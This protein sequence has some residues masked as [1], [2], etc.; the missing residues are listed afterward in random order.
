MMLC[1]T[2]LPASMGRGQQKANNCP[3]RSGISLTSLQSFTCIT[4]VLQ[5]CPF[6]A[7]GAC[8]APAMDE[9]CP[10][11]TTGSSRDGLGAAVIPGVGVVCFPG[12]EQI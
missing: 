9:L 6:A 4:S 3:K 5:K 7:P 8:R 11:A 1:S 2:A 12:P 10:A